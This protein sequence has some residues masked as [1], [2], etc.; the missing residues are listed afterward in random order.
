[1]KIAALADVGFGVKSLPLTFVELSREFVA[2]GR[3]RA[4]Y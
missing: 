1:M 3:T 2:P 4:I